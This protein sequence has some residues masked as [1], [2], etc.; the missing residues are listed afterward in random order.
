MLE[1]DIL[2]LENVANVDRLPAD[3][4]TIVLGALSIYDGSGSPLRILALTDLEECKCEGTNGA[5]RLRGPGDIA[6]AGLLAGL[7]LISMMM[8]Y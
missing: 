1:R 4:T 6:P 3:G 2:I 8:F 7:L 5:G